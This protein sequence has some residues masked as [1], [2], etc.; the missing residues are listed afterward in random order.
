MFR[1]FWG[2]LDNV[3]GL[4]IFWAT[5]LLIDFE[6]FDQESLQKSI[7]INSYFWKP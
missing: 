6:A 5:A 3:S 4:S 2:V 7:T 1:K